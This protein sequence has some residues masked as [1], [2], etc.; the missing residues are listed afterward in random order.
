MSAKINYIENALLVFIAYY[1]IGHLL[2]FDEIN[3]YNWALIPKFVL[4]IG[5]A[6]SILIIFRK[7]FLLYI[8]LFLC[9]ISLAKINP[10]VNS[11]SFP[12]IIFLAL[13]FGL[14]H[15][16]PSRKDLFHLAATGFLAYTVLNY[17]H[18]GLVKVFTKAWLDGT[19]VSALPA[20][21]VFRFSG[22][23]ISKD[24]AAILSWIVALLEISAFLIFFER[25]RKALCIMLFFMH[26]VIAI[27][28]P[29]LQLSIPYFLTLLWLYF[30]EKPQ[31]VK[32]A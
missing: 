25:F 23:Q 14:R 15:L 2:N 5:L 19:I 20:T 13:C 21:P 29:L 7:N 17:M 28:M 6:L 26:L 16:N 11:V 10:F 31:E 9:L 24:Y 27:T 8:L 22:L 30:Y 18:F 12:Q 1:F 3:F 4:S 32:S